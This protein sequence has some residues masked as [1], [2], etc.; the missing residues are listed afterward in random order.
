MFESTSKAGHPITG[1]A[2]TRALER[3]RIKY[4]ADLAPFSPHDL[5]R[6]VATGAAEYLDTPERLIELLLNHVPKD[7]LLRTYQVGGMA[8]KLRELC[9]RWGNFMASVTKSEHTKPDN[10]VSFVFRGEQ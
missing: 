7:R 2:V 6:S 4:L 1:D 3:V 10:V 8:D 9:L 5:R